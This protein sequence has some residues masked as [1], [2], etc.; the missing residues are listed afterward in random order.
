MEPKIK[1]ITLGDSGVGKT[2]II[3][4]IRDGKF[5]DKYQATINFDI[6]TKKKIYEKRNMT[7]S[8]IFHDTVGQEIYQT[9]LPVSYIHDSHVVL[10]VFS[11]LDTLDILKKRWYNFYKKNANVDGSRFILV[12]NK[13]DEFGDNRDEILKKG[14]QFADQLDAHFI[15]CSAKCEDNMDNLERYITTEAKRYIDE[16]EKKMNVIN[17]KI[18]LNNNN[19]NN[20]NDVVNR[21]KKCC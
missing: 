9:L 6:F 12:G 8:L 20:N 17:E 16:N 18:R 1:V 14:Q 19:T 3:S 11:D 21:K 4:R 2:S 7:F 15:T 10:L 13:S 5:S